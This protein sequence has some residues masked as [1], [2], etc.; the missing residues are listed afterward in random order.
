MKNKTT[1]FFIFVLMDSFG[2]NVREMT[3]RKKQIITLN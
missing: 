3:G 1:Y 2:E